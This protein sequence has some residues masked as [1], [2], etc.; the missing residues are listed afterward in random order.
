M[1]SPHV[2]TQ[3]RLADTAANVFRRWVEAILDGQLESGA[4]LRETVRRAAKAARRLCDGLL[5]HGFSP[6]IA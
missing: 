2:Q 3:K 6:H 4:P 1:S 5:P